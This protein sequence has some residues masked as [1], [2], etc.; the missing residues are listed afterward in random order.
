MQ[1]LNQIQSMRPILHFTQPPLP[2]SF[3]PLSSLHLLDLLSLP[4]ESLESDSL[5]RG[6]HGPCLLCLE[7]DPVLDVRP[8]KMVSPFGLNHIIGLS[9]CKE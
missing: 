8:V 3:Y 7:G 4:S 6:A 2:L 9:S 1:G 5:R